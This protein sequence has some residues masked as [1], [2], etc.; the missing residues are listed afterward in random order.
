MW[1]GAG[2]P[3]AAQVGVETTDE[4]IVLNFQNVDLSFA[5]TALAQAAGIN[6]VYANAPTT[7]VTLRTAA[8]VQP[9]EVAAMIRQL[10][11]AN[12][13]QVFEEPGFLRLQGPAN[14]DELVEPRQLYIYR[15]KHARSPLL[16]QTL[17]QLFGGGVIGPA[18]ARGTTTTPLSQQLNTLQG[19][20][21]AATQAPV[22][23]V[24]GQGSGDL[25]AE[26]QIV[27][28]ELTNTLLIRA[29]AADWLV[30]DQAIQALD[31]RPLQVVIEVVIAEVSRSADFEL[32]TSFSL[33]DANGGPTQDT[34]INL[35]NTAG[36]DAFTMQLIRPGSDIDVDATLSALASNGNVRILSR[37]LVQAQ[38]NQEARI[39]VGSE[40]PFVQVSQ[41]LA[42]DNA[43]L[44]QIV[45]YR[46]VG[47]ALTI[48]PT[49]NEDGYVNLLLSQEVNSATTETQFGAPI[50]STRE[51]TTQLLARSGQTVVIGGLM[52]QQTDE[53][54]SGIPF[55]KD[56]PV[57]GYLF[58]VKRETTINS[59]LFLFLTPY[60][61]TSDEE[62]DLLR[63]AIEGNLELMKALMPIRSILP[64]GLRALIPDSIGG[65]GG[66]AGGGRPGGG[67]GDG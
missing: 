21:G 64:L 38:N 48:L 39:L 67:S 30:V 32:G 58:G 44:Q 15:L 7:Q 23:V 54:R 57:L 14:Q 51:A 29:T 66:G 18:I 3:L 25:E 41:T 19:G 2:S 42:T 9:E 17:Q 22:Q 50:I 63:E 26:V 47:T 4:G 28:D 6:I 59:E 49:I 11:E 43:A 16:A 46:D 60:V 34:Q 52:A 1:S 31:L 55:L 10:A 35:P 65:V 40:R 33:T 53:S 27:P 24:V 37:P 20:G 45:Q 61:V 8:P 56:L 5:L 12:Q 13:M 62:A 36:L